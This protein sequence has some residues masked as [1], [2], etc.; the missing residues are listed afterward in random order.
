MKICL[1]NNLYKPYNRGGAENVVAAMIKAYQNS[2]HEVFLITTRPESLDL[3]ENKDCRT[4][5]I[6]SEFYNLNKKPKISRL[7][8]HLYNLRATKKYHAIKKILQAEKPDLVISHNLMGLDFKTAQTIQDL[9]IEHHHFLHD[10]QLLHPSGLIIY[11]QENSADSLSAKL[12]QK[13]T[14]FFLGSPDL[15][16]SP[17]RWLLDEHLKRGFFKKSKTEIKHLEDILNI[18]L[19]A[20]ANTKQPPFKNLLFAGQIEKHKGILFLLEAFEKLAGSEMKLT[21]AGDG[22]LLPL[23]R[24]RFSKDKRLKILGRLSKEN[25]EKSFEEADVLIVPSLCYE[26]YPLTIIEARQA[27]LPII[28]SGIG[29]IPEALKNGGWLFKP[30]DAES[31]FAEINK[32]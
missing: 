5:Y 2:G 32:N 17:S 27:E 25:L 12:Y 14:Q 16:I 19:P 15:I 9:K 6:S 1:L 26:N 23:I 29:G 11:G 8:W 21:I 4:F 20:T 28:A 3:G 13:A 10:I 31:L 22:S 30:G 7:F 18:K 24:E